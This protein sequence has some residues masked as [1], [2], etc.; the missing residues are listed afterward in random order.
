[1]PVESI[2]DLALEFF[3]RKEKEEEKEETEEAEAEA[4]RDTLSTHFE[5]PSFLRMDAKG[6]I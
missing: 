1:V 5:D 3:A 2:A 4:T 6:W